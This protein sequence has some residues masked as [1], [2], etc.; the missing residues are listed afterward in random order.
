MRHVNN[1]NGVSCSKKDSRQCKAN[2]PMTW[3][4]LFDFFVGLFLVSPAFKEE[5]M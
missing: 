2:Q 1:Y 4:L 5:V 3:F